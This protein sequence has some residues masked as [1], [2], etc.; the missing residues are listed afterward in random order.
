MCVCRVQGQIRDSF[1]QEVAEGRSG[2][3]HG[4]NPGLALGLTGTKATTSH[5]G[6][7]TGFQMFDHAPIWVQE[8][9]WPQSPA[10]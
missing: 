3:G 5:Q 6:H 7:E 4:M 10:P 8:P 1:L 9:Y 2:Q